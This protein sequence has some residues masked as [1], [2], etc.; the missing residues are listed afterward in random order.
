MTSQHK[1]FLSKIPVLAFCIFGRLNPRLFFPIA[2]GR[3]FSVF[4][5][6]LEEGLELFAGEGAFVFKFGVEGFAGT[7][8]L[9]VPVF[10]TRNILPHLFDGF[11][12]VEAGS[13]G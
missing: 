10:C 9:E 11:S 4:L 1:I 6:D 5:G 8:V 12:G 7:E 3:I 2:Y 13:Y